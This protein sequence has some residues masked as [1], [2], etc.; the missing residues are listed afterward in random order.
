MKQ[1]ICIVFMLIV[2]KSY[3]AAG[4]FNDLFHI[5]KVGSG[6]NV[7]IELGDTASFIYNFASGR[8]DFY[9]GV[10]RSFYY[11]SVGQLHVSNRDGVNDGG[12]L[13]LDAAGLNETVTLENDTG[14]L[15]AYAGAT[16]LFNAGTTTFDVDGNKITNLGTPTAAT[17]AATMA[18][19]DA[20]TGSD[21]SLGSIDVLQNKT[22]DDTNKI[23]T[24]KFR[25]SIELGD[26][27]VVS[28]LRDPLI[29][30]HATDGVDFNF[31]LHRANGTNGALNFN[32]LG[33][34]G[35]FFYANSQEVMKYSAPGWL[36]ISRE[37]SVSEGGQISLEPPLG[38]GY[39]TTAYLDNAINEFRVHNGVNEWLTTSLVNG[40]T[41][42]HNTAG[43][44]NVP[45]YCTTRNLTGSGTVQINCA[46]GEII[47]GGGCYDSGNTGIARGYPTNGLPAKGFQCR[48]VT[49]ATMT[50]Y[51]IC[52][53]Y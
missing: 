19:V 31:R 5:G 50:A 11:S 14:R 39:T 17:D 30:F 37:N 41:V 52:C 24:T 13:V 49:G 3:G 20:A 23:N 7:E 21:H 28:G 33:T 48:A 16:L 27:S 51:G 32:N 12:E 43:G 22:L 36:K 6:Q 53:V 26:D 25:H 8:M 4:S 9:V 40:A 45:H 46:A 47:T 42:M 29:D 2:A 38:G 10:D 34:A 44:G 18:Y 15:K 1:F 35:V